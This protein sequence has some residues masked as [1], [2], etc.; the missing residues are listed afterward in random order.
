MKSEFEFIDDDIRL[1][2]LQEA[3][4]MKK[5]CPHDSPLYACPLENFIM[6]G[7]PTQMQ[8]ARNVRE[9]AEVIRSSSLMPKKDKN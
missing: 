1:A 9:L 6:E 7:R 8:L 2:L 5:G 3:M 4:E